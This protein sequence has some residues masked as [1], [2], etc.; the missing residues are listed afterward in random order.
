MDPDALGAERQETF[1][2]L[3]EIG[4]FLFRMVSAIDVQQF[5]VV[6]GRIDAI[7]DESTLIERSQ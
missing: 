7:P 2:I 5:T 6:H 1:G 3:T 4:D